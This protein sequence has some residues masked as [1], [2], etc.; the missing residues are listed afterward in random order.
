MVLGLPRPILCLALQSRSTADCSSTAEP[1][2]K[3][4]TA[5]SFFSLLLG[6]LL[7]PIQYLDNAFFVLIFCPIK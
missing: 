5:L 2:S 7:I 4:E 1:F 3:K 6:K